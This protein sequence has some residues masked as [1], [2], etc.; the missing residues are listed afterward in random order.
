MHRTLVRSLLALT[1]AVMVVVGAGSAASAAPPDVTDYYLDGFQTETAGTGSATADTNVDRDLNLSAS[2]EATGGTKALIPILD[3]F[4]Y[5]TPSAASARAL[6]SG[7]ADGVTG[8]G[9]YL[10]TVTVDGVTSDVSETGNGQARVEAFAQVT[11]QTGLEQ[12][13]VAGQGT[14]EPTTDGSVTIEFEIVVPEDAAPGIQI[15]LR[16]FADATATGNA[17]SAA[18][19]GQLTDVTITP[20]G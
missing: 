16:A 3:L 1:A 13:A 17:A 12:F 15:E 20:V 11:Y 7:P 19:D 9:D 6:A 4:P 10:V 8:A 14:V 5:S 18:I 2:A